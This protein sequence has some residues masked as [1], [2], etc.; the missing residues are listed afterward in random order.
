MLGFG[1]SEFIWPFA[2]DLLVTDEA[3][4]IAFVVSVNVIDVLRETFYWAEW[5]YRDIFT[6]ARTADF[7]FG[8]YLNN[9]S[10]LF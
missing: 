6:K 3:G 4:A 1:S 5:V 2:M 8:F 7:I 9:P 10:G